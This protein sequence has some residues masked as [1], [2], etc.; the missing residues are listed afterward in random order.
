[1]RIGQ[2]IGLHYDGDELKISPFETEM[3]RRLWWQ[4]GMLEAAVGELSGFGPSTFVTSS[5]T[6][7]PTNLNDSDLDPN[8]EVLPPPRI[9]ATDVMFTRLRTAAGNIARKHRLGSL[10]MGNML[11]QSASQG[12]TKTLQKIISE[13]EE[14]I[15]R[16][17]LRYCD[18]L[19]PLHRL[20]SVTARVFLCRL[21]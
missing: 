9:G 17:F 19:D 15:E 4:I 8:M 12:I 14:L 1:M 21:R 18:Y 7:P 16:D 5:S 3:R 10:F 2:Y 13:M 20:S 6:K 11:K